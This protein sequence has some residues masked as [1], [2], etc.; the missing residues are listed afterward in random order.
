MKAYDAK[1]GKLN[2]FFTIIDAPYLFRYLL[3]NKESFI[4][5]LE[6]EEEEEE[7]DEQKQEKI[8]DEKPEKFEHYTIETDPK[9][10]KL[11]FTKKDVN[12]ETK[13]VF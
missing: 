4:T 6:K 3:N 10:Y 2:D 12:N 13:V 1:G 5:D 9:T 7:Q 8:E 11:K